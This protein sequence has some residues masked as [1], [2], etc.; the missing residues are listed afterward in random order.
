MYVKNVCIQN[1][2][3]FRSQMPRRMAQHG[4]RTSIQ[5]VP[6]CHA[7]PHTTGH[8]EL[9]LFSDSQ[10]AVEGSQEGNQAQLFLSEAK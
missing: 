1:N 2:L 10:Q 9:G 8:H 7:T 6:G 5:F 3:L 4:I